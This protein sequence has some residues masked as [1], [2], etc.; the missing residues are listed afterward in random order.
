MVRRAVEAARRTMVRRA[1]DAARR[2]GSQAGS[3]GTGPVGPI[4]RSPA[5]GWFAEPGTTHPSDVFPGRLGPA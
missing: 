2:H 5:R 3:A 1:M 4:R